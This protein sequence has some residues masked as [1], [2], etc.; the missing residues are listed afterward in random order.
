MEE[1]ADEPKYIKLM[2]EVSTASLPALQ[3]GYADRHL[4]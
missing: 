3:S 1:D 4:P 2:R